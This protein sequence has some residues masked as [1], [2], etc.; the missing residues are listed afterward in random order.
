MDT[1]NDPRDVL[2]KPWAAGRDDGPE[3]E[4]RH[5]VSLAFLNAFFEAFVAPKEDA[6]KRAGPQLLREI[7]IYANTRGTTRFMSLF[8]A[9]VGAPTAFVSFVWTMPFADLLAGLNDWA[10][11]TG[12]DRNTTFVCTWPGWVR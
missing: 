8:P 7:T 10:N 3:A 5:G 4:A 11:K 1:A 9:A 2:L 12:A 6:A